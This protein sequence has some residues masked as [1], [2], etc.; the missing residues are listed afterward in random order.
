MV[1]LDF[2]VVLERQGEAKYATHL[3]TMGNRPINSSLPM[4][5][6]ALCLCDKENLRWEAKRD[7]TFRTLL[8]ARSS[9]YLGRDMIGQ[10]DQ[11]YP[12]RLERK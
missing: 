2:A 4:L 9:R 3:V 10:L 11:S 7:T 8:C 12:G 6:L 1:W 5:R